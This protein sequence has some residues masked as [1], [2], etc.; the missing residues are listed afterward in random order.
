MPVVHISRYDLYILDN[1]NHDF[2]DPEQPIEFLAHQ[3]LL[4]YCYGHP[5]S[6]LLFFPYSPVVNYVNHNATQTNAKLR[7]AKT[8]PNHKSSWL[9]LSPDQL[10]EED[11]AGLIMELVATREIGPNEEIFIDYGSNWESRWS[12]HVQKWS[13]PLEEEYIKDYVAAS[14]LNERMEWIR[15]NDELEDDHP[16]PPNIMT[17][18]FVGHIRVKNEENFVWMYNEH[19]YAQKEDIRPCHVLEREGDI[20]LEDAFDRSSSV[21][22]V[23]ILYTVSVEMGEDHG[24]SQVF[25]NVP[26]KAIKFYDHQY[27]SDLFL[28]TAFRQEMDLPDAMVPKAWRDLD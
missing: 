16:Y 19:I 2:E 22:P 25:V 14:V 4:N 17:V 24:G 15:T 1:E 20:D 27:T 10:R 12:D 8:V 18:C 11:H 9:E 5:K 21:K 13:P 23:E 26:R 7:W 28:R 6:S 3:L